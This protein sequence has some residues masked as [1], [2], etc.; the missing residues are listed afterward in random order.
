MNGIKTEIMN[1]IMNGIII[2][3]TNEIMN[4]I[5]NEIMYGCIILF[6]ISYYWPYLIQYWPYLLLGFAPIVSY[7]F[8]VFVHH[9]EYL[10]V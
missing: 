2:E 6:I 1:E 4:V 8:H 3:I 7:K 10:S 5:I 9:F